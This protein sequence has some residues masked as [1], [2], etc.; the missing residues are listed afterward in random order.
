MESE[1]RKKLMYKTHNGYRDLSAE[2]AEAMNK[3]CEEYKHFLD[4]GK[5]ERECVATAIYLAETHGFME[6][7]EE[8]TYKPGDKLYYVNRDKEIY[9]V[10]M[11]QL[12]LSAGCNMS[13]AHTDSPRL[14]LKPQPLYEEAEMAWMKTRHYGTPRK[15]QWLNVPLAIHGVVALTDG[16][17]VI[18]KVGED[19]RDPQFLICDLQP[20][21][22][23][24][25]KKKTLEDAVPSEKLNLLV[26][27]RPC[28]GEEGGDLVKLEVLRLLHE[29]YGICEEDFLS[30]E[31]EVVPAAMARDMGFDRSFIMAYGH[32]D[33]VC[34]FAEL[35]AVLEVEM[36]RRT[37]LCV[38]ADKEEICSEG[39]TGTKSAAMDR[40]MDKLCKAQG[41]DLRDC[42]ANSFCLSA[43]VTGAYDPNF[44]QCF[45]K[46]NMSRCNHG[47]A[48]KKYTGPGGKGYASDASAEVM[49]YVRN[50]LNQ[51]GVLWQAG[52][53]GSNDMGG[54]GTLTRFIAARDIDSVDAG[55]P[56]L[57][58]H[59][60]CEVVAK[61]DCYMTYKA[62][63]AVF[64]A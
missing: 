31:L 13:L 5:T 10:V 38:F 62:I 55:V 39:V 15:Y 1:L 45:D 11:G 19:P 64:E 61:L 44:S 49:G 33:R 16:S 12:P 54:G 9:L 22:A 24:E 46:H 6:F 2:E 14:D 20:H 50:L 23:G 37:A 60:P 53:M 29:N 43:D 4:A 27:G 56:M 7:S 52:E 51:K 34:A 36:P 8:K 41:V 32:D 28:K 17:T 48:I 63:K 3:Y 40:F 26:G 21:L 42:Y 25:Q 18:V 35:K 30:A 58:M 59:A 47:V 57:S